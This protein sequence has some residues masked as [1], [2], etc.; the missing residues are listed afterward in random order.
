MNKEEIIRRRI[1]LNQQLIELKKIENA[2]HLTRL[3][4][5]ERQEN[6]LIEPSFAPERA[7]ESISSH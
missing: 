1:F 7:A 5:I 2:E 6:S 4:K 3:E